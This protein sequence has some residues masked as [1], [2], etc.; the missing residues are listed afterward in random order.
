MTHPM[1]LC[2]RYTLYIQ[3]STRASIARELRVECLLDVAVSGLSTSI[4]QECMHPPR[5]KRDKRSHAGKKRTWQCPSEGF[6]SGTTLCR[7]LVV[8]ALWNA[9]PMQ[10][11]SSSLSKRT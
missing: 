11:C 5:T 6:T 3:D 4:G 10:N 9:V 8:T 7:C 1:V 2:L